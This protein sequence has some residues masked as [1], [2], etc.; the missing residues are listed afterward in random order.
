MKTESNVINDMQCFA[1]GKSVTTKSAMFQIT[2]EFED[3][4]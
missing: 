3:Y 4:I 2:S 1:E